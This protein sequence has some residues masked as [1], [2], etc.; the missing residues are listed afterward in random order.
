[1]LK[2]KNQQSGKII[3]LRTKWINPYQDHPAD[4]LKIRKIL[5]E[6]IDKQRIIGLEARI[7]PGDVHQ[8]HLHLNDYVLVYTTSGKCKVTIGTRTKT[9]LP[10]TM[11]FIP[12]KVPHRFENKFSKRWEAIA[13][14]LG[15]D[16]KIKN[17][18]L[19]K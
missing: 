10:N 1:M 13:F 18:W 16:S 12:P 15:T 9:I 4:N 7:E 17:I 3:K 6:K 19:E 8:L 5:D 11:I 2:K 14:S